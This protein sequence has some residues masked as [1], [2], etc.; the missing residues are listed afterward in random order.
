MSSVIPSPEERNHKRDWHMVSDSP[1]DPAGVSASSF[2]STRQLSSPVISLNERANQPR[3]ATYPN[4]D[5]VVPIRPGP[6]QESGNEE[7]PRRSEKSNGRWLKKV[8]RRVR[9]NGVDT[10]RL[11]IIGLWILTPCSRGPSH[12][13][14]FSLADILENADCEDWSVVVDV[15]KQISTNEIEAKNAASILRKELK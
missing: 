8:L 13:S 2:Q 3:P 7:E 11:S 5:Y 14:T 4:I 12:V 15:C 9:S 6:I 1:V 10:F